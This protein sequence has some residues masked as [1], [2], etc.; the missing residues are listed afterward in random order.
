MVTPTQQ[1]LLNVLI[2]YK[3]K[4]KRS[5]VEMSVRSDVQGGRV[6]RTWYAILKSMDY[7]A[8]LFYDQVHRAMEKENERIFEEFYDGSECEINCADAD[9]SCECEGESSR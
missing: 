9:I 5:E 8:S 3:N 2:G 7:D 4:E 1:A 6:P